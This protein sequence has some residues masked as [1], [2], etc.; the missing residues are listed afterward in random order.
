MKARWVVAVVVAPLA[1]AGCGS[2]SMTPPAPADAQAK[3]TC[4][5]R[6]PHVVADLS[7]FGRET[8]FN[9]PRVAA[10]DWIAGHPDDDTW[11][12]RVSDV[13]RGRATVLVVRRDGTAHTQLRI[14]RGAAGWFVGGYQACASNN[15]LPEG[16]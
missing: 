5:A 15:P 16:Y 8:S 9:T 14:D 10:R 12:T 2:T 11:A 13:A 6:M 1:A 4:P 7:Y 3:I